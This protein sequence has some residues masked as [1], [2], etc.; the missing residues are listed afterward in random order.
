MGLPGLGAFHSLSRWSLG[1]T[2]GRPLIASK[3]FPR[4]NLTLSQISPSVSQKLS[5]FTSSP[6]NK[7]VERKRNPVEVQPQRKNMKWDCL[8]SNQGPS[9]YE[10]PALT[11]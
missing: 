6:E 4:S 1:L 3:V 10:S 5:L 11:D 9:D 8:D 2:S 7:G